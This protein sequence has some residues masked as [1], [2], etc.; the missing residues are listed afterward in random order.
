MK[1]SAPY[2]TFRYWLN[3][4]SDER[5]P[6]SA[7]SADGLSGL[8]IPNDGELLIGR[9]G[10]TPVSGQLIAGP[11]IG[12]DVGV[13]SITISGAGSLIYEVS[14]LGPTTTTSIT[15]VVLEQWLGAGGTV[16]TFTGTFE[17]TDDDTIVSLAFY[18]DGVLVPHSRR[19]HNIRNKERLAALSVT[20]KLPI[21]ATS[22]DVR[23]STDAGL[24]TCHER[25]L[26]I[27][28]CCLL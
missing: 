24:V 20:S 25:G 1:R 8:A 28:V 9:S 3:D 16:A 6:I 21:A 19:R 15:D 5:V 23:W 7:E 4:E 18:V 12:I 2:P 17:N 10:D 14:G 26:L 27:N 11:G 22:I 13:G